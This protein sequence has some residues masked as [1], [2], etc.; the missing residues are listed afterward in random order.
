MAM[1]LT[2]TLIITLTLTLTV[3]VTQA[4]PDAEDLHSLHDRG[5]DVTVAAAVNINIQSSE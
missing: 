5:Y 3:T 2:L 4:F 1:I